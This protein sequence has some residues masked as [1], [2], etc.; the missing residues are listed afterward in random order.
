[1]WYVWRIVRE[2]IAYRGAHNVL[3]ACAAIMKRRKRLRIQQQDGQ[4][5]VDIVDDVKLRQWFA[6]AEQARCAEDG[7]LAAWCAAWEVQ[8][9][10]RWPA[11][12]ASVA[13]GRALLTAER[14][15]VDRT[16][17]YAELNKRVTLA[18]D[19]ARSTAVTMPRP[20]KNRR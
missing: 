10:R 19:A 13:A 8:T 12:V 2:E 17:S 18:A 15:G 4:G 7:E 11:H 6:A 9:E 20:R 5:I 3:Q 14:S 16:L 1:M